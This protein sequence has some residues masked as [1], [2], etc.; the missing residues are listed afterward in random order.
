M[1]KTLRLLLVE[2]SN[3]DAI[4]ILRELNKQGYMLVCERVENAASME[5]ALNKQEWDI[6]I[7]D[8]V[9][10][11]F[12]GLDALKLLKERN[13]DLPC[14]I[15][16]GRIDD[17]TAVAAMKAGAK[18]YIMKDN[19][20]RMG[21]AV[22]RE[23]AEAQVRR[24]RRIAEEA[25]RQNEIKLDLI[26]EQM[27]CILWTTDT[28]L[29]ITSLLGAGLTA[30]NVKPKR[31]IGKP[32]SEYFQITDKNNTILLAHRTVLKGVP[33]SFEWENHDKFYYSYVEPLQNTDGT[34][35]GV[36]GLAFDITERKIS[37]ETH[38]RLASIVE[39]SNDAIIGETLDGIISSWNKGAEK[40]YGYSEKEV[41]GK[42]NSI[43]IAQDTGN[44][45]P[46]ILYKIRH[47]EKVTNYET[48]CVR[49]D[50]KRIN[51][52]LTASP[53]KN[54]LGE[55]VGA[56][57]I[58]RDITE[59][60]SMERRII[61]NNDV[62]KLFWQVS[63]KKDYAEKAVDILHNWCK[64]ECIGIRVIDEEEK[65]IPYLA[66]R[67]FD[68]GF[69]KLEGKLSLKNDQCACI[70]IILNKPDPQDYPALTRSGSF[71]LDNSQE[72]THKLTKSQLAKFRGVCINNGFLSIIIVP[73]RHHQ[74]I[75]GA[76]H[77]TDK[78]VAALSTGEL[79][80]LE[81]V[82]EL[83]GQGIYRFDIEEKIR[84]SES[85]L[86]EAQKIAHLGNWDWHIQTNKLYWSEE[87]YHIFGV[88]RHEFDATYDAF[89]SLVHPDDKIF[90]QDSVTLALSMRQHYNIVH[91]IILK[92][93]ST[94]FVHEQA[95]T[96]YD[97]DGRAIIMVGTVQ[98]ITEIK[99]IEE[100]LR[101]L[102]RRLVEV[103]E[104]ER[105]TIARE[106][107]DEI[108]QSLTALKMLLAQAS[109]QT[110]NNNVNALNEAK[111]VVS[112]L[113]QQVREMSLNLR[114]SMLDDL[115][116]LPSLLWHFDRFSS[117]TRIQIRFVHDGLQSS[118]HKLPPEV[119][120][121]AYRIVQEALTNIARYADTD[122]AD[123][124]I[125][126]HNDTLYIKIEDKGRGFSFSELQARTSTGLSGMR[127]RVNL[128]NGKLTMES[129]P[130]E[131]T[132]IYVELPVRNISEK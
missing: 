108:G 93:G 114:P 69:M 100:E 129:S 35:I 1:S 20:K 110:T 10:P 33:I 130:G 72:F 74:S 83:I 16:S 82:A 41:L 7:S 13:L 92:D 109:H 40:I 77:I 45:T 47:D 120:T 102:S 117:Q 38:R 79:E 26:L 84:A 116:L 56:S 98:D 62:M 122:K 126:F 4:L 67:G 113:M 11:S 111:N 78:K 24:K 8:Y 17:E 87:I 85:R 118:G 96:S 76:I 89:L 21:P 27:P 57:T 32:L 65:T 37:E 31:L 60:K 58:A 46:L 90:V 123:V 50:G 61:L 103:Q 59:Q 42:S 64:C 9:L 39:S 2:D 18:D 12:S 44:D 14:I 105:R 131:G 75:L 28:S 53:V 66:Y 121:S 101:A 125:R 95:K 94:R 81:S 112:D 43:L 51:V 71:Y 54:E 99:R 107:H 97:S 124:D 104:N 30:M 48:M 15:T 49:K 19:L 55:I 115:G 80:T 34:I 88:S 63:T 132:R 22:E 86:A 106:L 3:N 119:N 73:M 127:E 6:V 68:Q 25:L 5:T 36:I 70:R 23:L 29:V 52:S 128:L 91:R